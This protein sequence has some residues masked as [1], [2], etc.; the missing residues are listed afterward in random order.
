MLSVFELREKDNQRRIKNHECYKEILNDVYVKIKKRNEQHFQNLIYNIP[1]FK[2]GWPPINIENAIKYCIMKLN[3]G[4][5]VAYPYGCL[6][7]LYVDWSVNLK[8]IK[9]SYTKKPKQVIKPIRKNHSE[10]SD[11]KLNHYI[12]LYTKHN[13]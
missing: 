5:F 2:L 6:N 11:D 4:G 1:H 12:Q 9:S 8:N 3:K 7:S 13:S 10:I